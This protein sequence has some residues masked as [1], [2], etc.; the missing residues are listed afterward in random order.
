M[1]ELDWKLVGVFSMFSKKAV[2]FKVV[3]EFRSYFVLILF[4]IL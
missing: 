4:L 2:D 3:D 1:N